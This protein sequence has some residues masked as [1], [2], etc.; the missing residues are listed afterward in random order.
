MLRCLLMGVILFVSPA[1]AGMCGDS[2]GSVNCTDEAG[3]NSTLESLDHA[4]VSP[5]GVTAKPDFSLVN[6]DMATQPRDPKSG[7]KPT[8]SE[9]ET[10]ASP[11]TTFITSDTKTRTK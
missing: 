3:R 7:E 9:S 4:L 8:R 6:S 11:E 10:E 5:S 1:Y 2:D